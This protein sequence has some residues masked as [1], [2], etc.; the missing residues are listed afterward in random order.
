MRLQEQCPNQQQ[1]NHQ[2][3]LKTR[4]RKRFPVLLVFTHSVAKKEQDSKPASLDKNFEV[5]RDV[6]PPAMT[7]SGASEANGLI[8]R[9]HV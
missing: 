8:E 6:L 4:D 7:L 9:V 2:L 5:K 1:L 3:D